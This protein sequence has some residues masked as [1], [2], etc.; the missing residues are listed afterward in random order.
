MQVASIDETVG[1]NFA[2]GTPDA[3]WMK[4]EPLEA[5]TQTLERSAEVR[6]P[7]VLEVKQRRYRPEQHRN[8]AERPRKD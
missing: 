2:S 8:A 6:V 1:Q 4:E 3:D 5:L 7:R